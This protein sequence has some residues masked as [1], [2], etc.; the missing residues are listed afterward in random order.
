MTVSRLA[1]GG[2]FIF[3]A[4]AAVLLVWPASSSAQTCGTAYVLSEGDTLADI[5]RKV[6]GSASQWS[7]IYYANQERLGENATL[8]VPG[9]AIKVPCIGPQAKPAVPAAVDAS[10]APVDGGAEQPAFQLS[11]MLK[12]IEF[13]TAEGYPPFTG[14]SLPEG[15]LIVDLLQSSMNLIKEQAKGS[16]T[17]RCH[18]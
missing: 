3:A 6:Y 4:L 14:R 9:L 17:I 18:G 16:S 5:A 7:V 11:S 13:L 10:P 15:G 12:R 1:S 2:R 8:L